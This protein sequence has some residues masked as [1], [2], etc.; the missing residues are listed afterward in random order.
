MSVF[1]LLIHVVIILLVFT[2]VSIASLHFL[3][4]RPRGGML[5]APEVNSNVANKNLPEAQWFTQRLDHFDDSNTHTWQQRYFYNDSFYNNFDGPVFVMIGGEGEANPIWL[6]VGDM[7]KNAQVFGAFTF[8]LEHRFYGKSRPTSDMSDASLRYLNSEQAIADLAVFRVVMSKKFNLTSNKWISFG[9]SYSGSLSAWFRLKYPHL[10]D[11]AVA[12]S[13]PV[14]AK[15]NFQEYM[16]VVTASL[17]TT[18]PDCTKNVANATDRLHSLLS[19]QEGADQLTELFLLCEPLDKDNVDDV[20]TFAMD[21]SGNFAGVVQYNKDNRAFEGAVGTNITIKT[22]CDIMNDDDIGEPLAR[23]AKINTLIL[24][25][26]GSSCLDS[27][28]KSMITSLQNTSWSSSASEGG[29]QWTYQTCTEFG[30]Y[31]T[32]DSDTQPFGKLFPL[33]FFIQQ[34]MDI[35]GPQFN[36]TNIQNGVDQT[37]TNYG[38]YEIS[39]SKIIFPNGS[40]DPW[41]ALGILKDASSTEHAIYIEG[42]AHCANM[43][44]ASPSDIP[45]LVEARQAIQD[46]IKSWLAEDSPVQRV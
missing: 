10:V 5:G 39:S 13:A 37:N 23:Y 18:G 16:D 4:G 8:L 7:M 24:Q 35:F 17:G 25:T 29:R 9:G 21:L 26:Y 38:G 15:L 3:R 30:F 2:N 43:Y 14:F 34:C 45:Q 20:A 36:A 6:T 28:Y 22:L 41:H 27:S 44:P 12:T 32:S 19:S 42:T 40:I 31:Q 33:K 1:K 46:Q 11:A